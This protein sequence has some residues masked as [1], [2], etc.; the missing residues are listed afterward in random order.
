MRRT[1]ATDRR[2]AALRV[3]LNSHISISRSEGPIPIKELLSEPTKAAGYLSQSCMRVFEGRSEHR[4]I[5]RQ[6]DYLAY[7]K[8]IESRSNEVTPAILDLIQSHEAGEVSE[9]EVE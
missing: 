2:L 8:E 4:S 9:N 3:R 5:A 1:R 6:L 7:G